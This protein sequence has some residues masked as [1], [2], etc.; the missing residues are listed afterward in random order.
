[1][2]EKEKDVYMSDFNLYVIRVCLFVTQVLIAFHNVINII[3]QRIYVYIILSYKC[4]LD[5]NRI[6]FYHYILL[7]Y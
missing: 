6:T 2:R 3:F 7:Y 4:N 5:N 1:M